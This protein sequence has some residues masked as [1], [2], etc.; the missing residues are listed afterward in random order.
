[1]KILP[2]TTLVL[3]IFCTVALPFSA[4]AEVNLQKLVTTCEGCHGSNG[5]SSNP[6][7]PI[8][9]GNSYDGF[10][11]TL[12]A[13]RDDERIAIKFQAPGEPE[14]VMND[15]AKALSDDEVEALA[16]H[17]SAKKFNPAKQEVNLELAKQGAKIHEESCAKC[18]ADGGGD[19]QDDAA[20]LAGQ[21]MK[22]LTRQFKNIETGK[23]I[24]PKKMEKKVS[25]LSMSD[26]EALV[27]FYGSN[28]LS[29][30]AAK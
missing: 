23:R 6:D 8:I 2:T 15:I 22:Y 28:N 14:T 11:D 26:K 4:T 18:H 17:F 10:F 24:V 20:I 1:M 21:W 16:K 29:S 27:H 9:A 3:F 30:S 13:F 12:A 5:N 19:P 25:K 7:V